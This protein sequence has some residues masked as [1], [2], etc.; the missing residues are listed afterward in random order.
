[1]IS[2]GTFGYG[3][4]WL[5]GSTCRPAGPTKLFFNHIS[6]FDALGFVAP[7]LHSFLLALTLCISVMACS[8]SQQWQKCMTPPILKEYKSTLA[9]VHLFCSCVLPVV[10]RNRISIFCV[11]FIIS[12]LSLCSVLTEYKQLCPEV[13]EVSGNVS[14]EDNTRNQIL[15][16]KK[17][18]QNKQFCSC[19]IS[20]CNIFINSSAASI[21]TS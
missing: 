5:G 7:R 14:Y 19:T 10:K 20:F 4:W 8:A 13:T 1:M 17:V 18:G 11:V 15:G 12:D 2:K 3:F 9:L 16:H 6:H 21:I